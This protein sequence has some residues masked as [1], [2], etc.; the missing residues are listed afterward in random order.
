MTKANGLIE[1]LGDDTFEVRQKAEADL[2]KMGGT[3]MPLLRQALKNSDLEIRN[4]AQKVL[5]Q[6]EMDKT[7]PLNP[8][9]PRL[10]A[11]RKPK[12]AVEAILA[13]IPF[14][15]DE[16][17]IDELQVALNMTAFPKGKAHPAVL[18][19]L[20]DK[21]AARRG[22]AAAALCN[23]PLTEYLPQIRKLLRDKDDNVKLKVAL[24]LAGA[25]EPE[26]VPALI[27][28]VGE[29][30]AEGSGTAEDYL[31]RLARDNPPKD[32]PD[33]DD[34]RKKRAAAWDKWW[35][36]NKAK[37]VMVD[38][39][40]PEMRRRY[41]GYTLLIQSNNNQIVE[42]DQK[43]QV[44]MTMTNLA[45][46]WDAQWVSNN[47]L[48][49]A[50]Y[51][52]QRVTERNLK[53][54][55]VWEKKCNFYP[56][57]VYRLK[58]GHTFI[59][60]ANALLQVDRGG[61]QVLRIDRPHDIRSARRLDNG[62][63]VVVTSNRQILRLD[64]NGKELKSATVPTVYYYQNEILRNGNVLIPTGW[65]NRLIEYNADGKEVWSVT[66][67]Q[68]MHAV[69]LRNGN[70][71]ISSQNFPYKFFEVDKNGKQLY[72]H[73]TNIYVFRIRRR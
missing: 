40:T 26:A 24:A 60:G 52:G 46:P 66:T 61:R 69:R 72:E 34:A 20:G 31:L 30:P 71:V 47:R 22:A 42:L 48:L 43:H 41:L 23:G 28:L 4:R 49:I 10:L 15:D 36:D 33:G 57:Q 27:R 70:T 6:L 51:N 13:Y 5:T 65:N 63:I 62:Q 1:K 45:S 19:A 54:E 8:V 38:R 53:G 2:L 25:R 12:G 55:V 56:M 44:R 16:S 73:V 11:L 3:I 9:I 67:Q 64:R 37:V 59:V 7:V 21:I 14:A 18:K 29:L 39:F 17:I 50:E 35:T 68:P 58:N 32:L